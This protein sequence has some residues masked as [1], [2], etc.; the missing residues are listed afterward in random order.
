MT[1]NH[2]YPKRVEINTENPQMRWINRACDILKEGGIIVYPTD[3]RYGL[4]CDIFNK[5]AIERIYRIKEKD[6]HH[7][8]SFIFPDLKNM[9]LY[10]HIDTGSYKILKR[11]LPG[12]YTFIL[13]ATRE[14]PKIMLTKRRTVGI[15]IPDNPIVQAL[16]DALDNPILNSSVGAEEELWVNDPE[17]IEEHIGHAVDLILDGGIIISEPS[18]VIDLTEETPVVIRKGKGDP[19]LVY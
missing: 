12:P 18:T 16:V 10:V 19:A 1:V 4:G 3:S 5:K 6:K 15:R 11:C 13:R 2:N 8:M 9:S 7:P 14:I 17:Q